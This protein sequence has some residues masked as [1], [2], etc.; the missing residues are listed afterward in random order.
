MLRLPRRDRSLR[1]EGDAPRRIRTAQR[2]RLRRSWAGVGAGTSLVLALLTALVGCTG[3]PTAATVTVINVYPASER[4]PAP[5][6]RGE[7]L[8]ASGTFDLGAHAGDV[9]VV[10]FWASW[11][12]PCVAEADDLEQTYQST[13]ADGVA[14]LGINTRDDREPARAFLRGRSTYP[15]VFDPTGRLALGFKVPP[16]AIPATIVIDRKG[17]IAAVARRAILHS[18]L[19]PVV[20]Q[21]AAESP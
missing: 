8:G 21:L 2:D 1:Y 19:E 12:G 17:R 7:L 15:S 14:F 13:K 16:N 4:V 9:V 6:L 11:C 3:S 18:E 20:A 10:N 5:A